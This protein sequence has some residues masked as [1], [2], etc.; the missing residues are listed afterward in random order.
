MPRT[1]GTASRAGVDPEIRVRGLTD[2]F[3]VYVSP[4]QQTFPHPAPP[5]ISA[6]ELVFAVHLYLLI[7]L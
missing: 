5:T 4:C 7:T 3:F 2:S 6:T 1:G